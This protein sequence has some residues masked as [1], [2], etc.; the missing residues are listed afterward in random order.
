M[1]SRALEAAIIVLGVCAMLVLI[2]LPRDGASDLTGV[3]AALVSI[4]DWAFLLGPGVMPAVNALYLGTVMYRSGLVPRIIPTV[5]LIGAP[6]L[7][8]SDVATLFGSLDQVSTLAGVAALPIALWE[9][10]LGIWLVVKGFRPEAFAA[11][12]ARPDSLEITRA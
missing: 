3:D 5:G 9:I 10:S 2:D 11:L 4:H 7:I 6:I 12:A 1:A 8:V